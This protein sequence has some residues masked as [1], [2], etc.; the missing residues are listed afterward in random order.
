MTIVQFYDKIGGNYSEVEGRLGSG[1][2]AKYFAMKFPKDPSF[3]SLK[4]ALAEGDA[5]T[6]FRAAHT[7]KGVC[8]NLGFENLYRPAFE[9]TEK[10]RGRSLEGA[11]S[12]FH[13]VEKEYTALMAA[14]AEVE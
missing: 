13:E 10:L 11:E 3:G 14:L 7:L 6:A 4:K 2:T 5:E 1:E 9:L 12:L 8:Q